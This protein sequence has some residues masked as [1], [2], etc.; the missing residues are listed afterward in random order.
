MYRK[1]LRRPQLAITAAVAAFALIAAGC[2]S[3][4]DSSSSPASTAASST[5]AESTPAESTPAESTPAESAPAA[6]GD[7]PSGDTC[8]EGDTV[9]LGFLN[10]TSGAMAI[11]EQTV[12]DSLLLAAEEINAAG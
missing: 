7:V 5:P 1:P 2:G 10:S 9:E 12:R 11:S 6:S 3:D 4:D 8:V